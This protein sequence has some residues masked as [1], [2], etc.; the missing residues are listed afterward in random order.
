MLAALGIGGAQAYPSM[1]SSK[2]AGN[3]FMTPQAAM[4]PHLAPELKYVC[5]VLSGVSG[6][7]TDGAGRVGV[8]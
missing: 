7:A 2:F 5:L 8:D 1:F 4:G 6:D 3:C